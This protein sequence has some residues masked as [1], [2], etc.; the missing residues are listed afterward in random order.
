M[1]RLPLLED[2]N[3][4]EHEPIEKGDEEQN[5]RVQAKTDAANVEGLENVVA[6][7]CALVGGDDRAWEVAETAAVGKL[8]AGELDAVEVIEDEEVKRVCLSAMCEVGLK[9][10]DKGEQRAY[11]IID[12]VCPVVPESREIHGSDEVPADTLARVASASCCGREAEKNMKLTI[13]NPFKNEATASA[14][15]KIGR[16]AATTAD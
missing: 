4:V 16:I 14:A 5:D 15:T 2:K 11:L 13:Q 6:G 1:R 9:F 3:N 10:E 12:E 8:R 7:E